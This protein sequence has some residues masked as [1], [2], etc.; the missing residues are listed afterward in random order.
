MVL[1]RLVFLLLSDFLV[2][3]RARKESLSC[4]YSAGQ[5]QNTEL[6]DSE[7]VVASMSS[8]KGVATCMK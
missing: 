4:Q 2:G 3:V 8:R 5:D 1:R 7:L 6:V